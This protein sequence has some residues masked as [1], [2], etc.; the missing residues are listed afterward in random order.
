MHVAKFDGRSANFYL[1]KKIVSSYT[2]FRM[3]ARKYLTY[4]QP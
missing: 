2:T 1:K 3:R 4:N